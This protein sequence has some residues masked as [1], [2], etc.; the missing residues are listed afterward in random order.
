MKIQRL[1]FKF[2]NTRLSCIRLYTENNKKIKKATINRMQWNFNTL[3]DFVDI[4]CNA[5]K[6]YIK[7][8]DN[9][10]WR[11]NFPIGE[12]TMNNEL[13]INSNNYLFE[14]ILDNPNLQTDEIKDWELLIYITFNY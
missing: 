1:K 4:R 13:S 3:T 10:L 7:Y 5:I 12:V 2:D 14:I 8:Q 6:D 9:Y 11:I